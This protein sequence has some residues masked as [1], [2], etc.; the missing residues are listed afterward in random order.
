M[1]LSLVG[2]QFYSLYEKHMEKM[3]VKKGGSSLSWRTKTT[4]TMVSQYKQATQHPS[5]RKPEPF[6]LSQ[7]HLVIA[8]EFES[9]R[10]TILN[11]QRSLDA[12]T[13]SLVTVQRKSSAP[14]GSKASATSRRSMTVGQRIPVRIDPSMELKSF[15]IMDSLL[16]FSLV[17]ETLQEAPVDF[18]AFEEDDDFHMNIF[19]TSHSPCHASE[20]DELERDD[21]FQQ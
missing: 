8:H 1:P 4:I 5:A 20:M 21:T 11:L 7:E 19:S 15:A 3:I 10:L 16:Q 14:K 6:T 2:K 17:V 9:M 13:S 12:T 18:E